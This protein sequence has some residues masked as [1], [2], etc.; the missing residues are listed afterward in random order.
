M[1]PGGQRPLAHELWCNDTF[2]GGRSGSNGDKEAWL[3]I[4]TA[5]DRSSAP[6]PSTAPL[7]APQRRTTGVRCGGIEASGAI[8]AVAMAASALT[9]VI[10]LATA[11]AFTLLIPPAVVDIRAQ[12]LPDRWILAA[13]LAFG[14][15]VVMTA[16][17]GDTIAA[18]GIALGALAMAAPI[19]SLHLVSPAAMGFGDVKLSV[20]LGAA[21]GV[22]EWRLALV[23][24]CVAGL[25]GA[26]YGIATR[27]TTVPFGPFLLVGSV[28]AIALSGPLLAA[29]E[30]GAA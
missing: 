15:A 29:I 19:V 1:E 16:L 2:R 22:V 17:L 11:I 3:G 27:R 5:P 6:A 12:R 8:G 30:L 24:L 4:P 14:V 23:A 9:G 25:F 21:I 18:R 26:A 10:P 13:A 7:P 20:V 28:T